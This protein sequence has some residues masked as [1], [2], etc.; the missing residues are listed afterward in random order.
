MVISNIIG[1]LGNQMFQYAFGRA[2]S[3]EY[4]CHHRVDLDGYRYIKQHQGFLLEKLFDAPVISATQKELSDLLGRAWRFLPSRHTT[5]PFS[6]F[7]LSRRYFEQDINNEPGVELS[8][9]TVPCY[10][11]GYWQSEIFFAKHANQIV[12]DFR[13]VP[14]LDSRNADIASEI[15]GCNSLSIHV[16]RGDYVCTPEAMAEYAVCDQNYYRRAIDKVSGL[17]SI[18]KVFVFSDDI[19]WVKKNITIE[20]PSEYIGHN[21]GQTSFVDMQLMTFSRNHI[22]ANSSFSWWGAWLAQANRTAPGIVIAPYRWGLR[23]P[24]PIGVPARTWI[25]V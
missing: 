18:D 2:L 12:K 5:K 19:E 11:K 21:S 1:G 14:E 25:Q 22:V 13:F 24:F 8:K 23:P 6:K 4:G 15:A 16:R 17:T 10:L 3:L 9:V 7:I 20:Y